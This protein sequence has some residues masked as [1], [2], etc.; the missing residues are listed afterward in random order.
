MVL[1]D[2]T[3]YL[4]RGSELLYEIQTDLNKIETTPK[5]LVYYTGCFLS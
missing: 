5:R 2:K 4:V 1:E 3:V